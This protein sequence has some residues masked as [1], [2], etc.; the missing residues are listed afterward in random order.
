MGLTITLI[1]VGMTVLISYQAFND[2]NMKA[3]L[4]LYPVGMK[5]SGEYY[6]FLSSGF[7]HAD[8]MHLIINMYVLYTFGEMIEPLFDKLFGQPWG[9]I[10]FLLVYVG[11]IIFGSIPSYF[12]HQDNSAYAA[13]GA[14]GGTSGVVFAF[15]VFAPWE[16]FIFPPLPGV[17]MAIGYLWYSSYMGKRGGDNIGHD[18]HFWGAVFGFVS[19]IVLVGI[20]RP[21]VLPVL[22]DQLLAGPKMPNF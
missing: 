7:I 14:S 13:L 1:L 18:A 20:L 8:W 4:M 22:W 15:I 11:S 12:K 10:Y 9:R 2:R 6:R 19:T 16:W 17:L 5:R 21:D 3:K